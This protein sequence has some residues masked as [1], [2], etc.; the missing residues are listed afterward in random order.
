VR[1]HRRW[2]ALGLLLAGLTGCRPAGS[3]DSGPAEGSGSGPIAVSSSY[4][5]AALRDLLGEDVSLLVLA[6]P[7]MCPGHFDLRPS[8]VQELRACPILAR[9]D[10]QNS[11]DVRLTDGAATQVVAVSVPGGMCEPASYR[12]VCRQLADAL[13][14]R[15]RLSRADADRRLA[16]VG[17][18]MDQLAAWTCEQIDA[19]KLRDC[20]VV[21][22]GHQSGFCSALGLSVAATFSSADTA[23]PRQI[24]QAVKKGDEARA[25]LIVANR[26]EGRQLADA[27]GDRLKARVLVFGNFPDGRSPESFDRLVRDNVTTL[28][29]ASRQIKR[30]SK[31]PAS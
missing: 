9:F 31:D 13:V 5:G 23:Q 25:C 26:P 10:F 8:Q 17:R 27:L 14:A 15:E 21:C 28:I 3:S 4:L 2:I 22:S 19:A 30:D 1:A 11:L 20:P 12:D 29:E 6:E 7:G 24:D 18:R 16:A